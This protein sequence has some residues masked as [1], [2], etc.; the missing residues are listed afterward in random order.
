MEIWLRVILVLA[1][2]D[3]QLSA[4]KNDWTGQQ[5]ERE[6]RGRDL[7][8]GQDNKVIQRNNSDQAREKRKA[9]SANV[10]RW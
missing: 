4:E 2:G 3:A 9:I 7:P 1:L 10:H 8:I 5:R 6:R